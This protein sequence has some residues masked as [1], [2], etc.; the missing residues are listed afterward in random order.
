M[1]GNLHWRTNCQWRPS[2]RGLKAVKTLGLGVLG[3]ATFPNPAA[4]GRPSVPRGYRGRRIPYN[5]GIVLSEQKIQKYN[6]KQEHSPV[7]N[8]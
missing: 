2:R 6:S 5:V 3:R 4:A 1:T 7:G 8:R